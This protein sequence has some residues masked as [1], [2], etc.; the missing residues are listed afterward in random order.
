MY[1]EQ[2]V[3]Q[4]TQIAKKTLNW[5]GLYYQLLGE[6]RI[7][8]LR[9][10]LVATVSLFGWDWTASTI[11]GCQDLHKMLEVIHHDWFQSVDDEC[12]VLGLLDI[13]TSLILESRPRSAIRPALFDSLTKHARILAEIAQRCG[14]DAMATRPFIQWILAK[15][16]TELR[17]T[18]RYRDETINDSDGLLVDQGENIQ[19]PIFVPVDHSKKPSWHAFSVTSTASQRSAVKVAYRAAIHTDDLH[20]Q[21]VSLKLLCLLSQ[22]PT[23][24]L[25]T[26]TLLQ[27]SMQG[28]TDGFLSTYLARYLLVQNRLDANN[29][30]EDLTSFYKASEKSLLASGANPALLWSLDVIKGHLV[31]GTTRRKTSTTTGWKRNLRV[32]GSR[33][34]G[35]IVNF[36]KCHFDLPVPPP[37]PPPVRFS[38][39]TK[40][41]DDQPP[42]QDVPEQ[43]K[44]MATTHVLP[45]HL[46]QIN[47]DHEPRNTQQDEAAKNV[48]PSH[49]V[50]PKA[51][52][53]SSSAHDLRPPSP[54]QSPNVHMQSRRRLSESDFGT[55]VIDSR[56]VERRFK[57]QSPPNAIR[58]SEDAMSKTSASLSSH[59]NQSRSVFGYR[60]QENDSLVL[61]NK[62]SHERERSVDHPVADVNMSHH[63]PEEAVIIEEHK[64]NE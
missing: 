25:E 22:D 12:T 6:D 35:Y 63:D 46:S 23:G 19:L 21:A 58:P 1:H 9:D 28:D 37:I 18:G 59:W 29:L 42:S 17:P 57:D 60:E 44:P 56:L 5:R 36:I 33:L 27:T 38:G 39:S 34:P 3:Y 15:T 11:F 26:L 16:V 45:S 24:P 50:Q 13:F 2:V 53:H 14:P 30:L 40:A 10:L 7:W 47:G 49:T 51:P 8:D 61:R 43:P 32:Y 62:G 31:P 41:Q 52:L 20:L 4:T 55:Q 54:S 48:H 64:E